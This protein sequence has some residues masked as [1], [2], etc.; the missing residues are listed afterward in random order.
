MTSAEPMVSN[1]VVEGSGTTADSMEIVHD[2]NGGSISG[3]PVKVSRISMRLRCTWIFPDGGIS[4]AGDVP[5]TLVPGN[6]FVV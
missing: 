4:M 3:V 2:T 6:G 5:L 1:R